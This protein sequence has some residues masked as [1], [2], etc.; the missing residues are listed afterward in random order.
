MDIRYPLGLM[1]AIVGALLAGFGLMTMSSTM[2]AKHSLG[3]N[4]NL[5][6]GLG[7]LAFG[8]TVLWL[9]RRAASKTPPR[10]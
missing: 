2:Y 7:M 3:V 9:A 6:S 1:F 4:V 10:H 5:W 8:L